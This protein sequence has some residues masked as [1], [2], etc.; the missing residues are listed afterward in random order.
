MQELY[1]CSHHAAHF[2]LF[3]CRSMTTRYAFCMYCVSVYQVADFGH[4]GLLPAGKTLLYTRDCGTLG[5]KAPE[6]RDGCKDGH[7]LAVSRTEQMV[8]PPHSPDQSVAT[9]EVLH[10]AT[11]FVKPSPLAIHCVFSPEYR[12]ET[13]PSTLTSATPVLEPLLSGCWPELHKRGG[14]RLYRSCFGGV[15]LHWI[16]ASRIQNEEFLYITPRFD[17]CC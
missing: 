11:L 7:G 17:I 3:L 14:I 9:A 4:A 6:M 5:Y 8:T 2:G 13:L 15:V 16:D 10:V 1:H 12:R